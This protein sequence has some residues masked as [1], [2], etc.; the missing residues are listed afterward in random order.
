MSPLKN[1][2]FTGSL[3]VFVFVGLLQGPS[4]AFFYRGGGIGVGARAMGLSGAF[5]AVA[6]D[7]SAAYWNP[8]GFSQ[9]DRPEVMV[10]AGSYFDDKDRNLFLSFHYPVEKDIHVAVSENS[11]FYTDLPGSDENNLIGSVAIPLDFVPEKILSF[12]ANFK[13]FLADLGAGNGTAQGFGVDVGVLYRRSF[14]DKTMI[15]GALVLSDISTT[16]RFDST[17]IEQVVPAILTAGLAYEFD[18]STLVAVDVPWTLSDD[19]ILDNQNVRFR[20][21]VE[22]WFFD[23]RFGL[24]AGFVSFL[25]LPGEFSVG[26][27]YR[28]DDWSVDYAF[29]NHSENLGNSHRLDAHYYFGEGAGVP[30]PKP[31]L[32]QALTGDQKI[33]LKWN[34]PEG[35][36]VSGFLV[37][38]REEGEKDFHR[39]KQDLL[40]TRFCLLRGAKN[41]VRYHLY[42]R[43]V[44][45]DQERYSSDE[46]TVDTRPMSAEA[47]KYYD[48]GLDEFRADHISAAQYSAHKAETFDPN[49]YDIKDLIQKLET[50]THEGL[51][52]EGTKP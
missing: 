47:K 41:G 32:V 24:R 10:M 44:V 6:D 21:G 11:L 19:P 22:H 39:A 14:P 46:W 49:D 20:S 1:R 27:G 4:H 9:L 29:M 5:T 40:R 35:S 43:S 15:K 25:T 16:M 33:F 30:I 51:A 42:I 8:A 2:F 34:I 26:A 45:G 38:I 31:Y 18:P 12:G 48:H 7:P 50:T 28:A 36:D 13:Y 52:P 23:R 17:G 37:Y 3:V